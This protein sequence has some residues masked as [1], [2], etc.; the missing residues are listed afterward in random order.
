MSSSLKHLEDIGYEVFGNFPLSQVDP[1]ITES[2]LDQQPIAIGCTGGKHRSVF[3]VETLKDWLAEQS[4][5]THSL[6][7]DIDRA[8]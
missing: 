8:A 1:L 4:L 5:T 7:R 2:D 6:H 3:T